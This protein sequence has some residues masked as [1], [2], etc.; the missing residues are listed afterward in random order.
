[1]KLKG[2]INMAVSG[3]YCSEVFT[4][5]KL[6]KMNKVTQFAEQ[7]LLGYLHAKRGYSLIDLIT[8][9]GLSNAE[10][11]QIKKESSLCMTNAEVQEIE[12]YFLKTAIKIAK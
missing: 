5:F 9:M 6:N 8:S 12:L 7:Q 10:W 4:F 11:K 3:S 1:M 2:I